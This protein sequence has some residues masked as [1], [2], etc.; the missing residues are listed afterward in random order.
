M[1]EPR[2]PD[3]AS[4]PPR[5][6]RALDPAAFAAGVRASL[7]VLAGVV[8]FG[9]VCG[10]ALAASGIAPAAAVAM[11]LLVFAGA[12]MIAA[13]QLLA[14]GTPAALVVLAAFCI[15]LRF[16]MYSATLRPHFGGMPLRWRLGLAYLLADNPYALAL[17][18]FAERPAALPERLGF[19]LGASLPVWGAWQ[20]AVAAGAYGGARLPAHW[21][22][23]FAAP[24]AFIAIT[25]PFLRGRPAVAAA[26]ASAV[27]SVAL[28]AL[29]WRLGVVVAA[30]A[31]IGAALLAERTGRR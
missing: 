12:S 30:A 8:P 16:A 11:S 27:T 2:G 4:V 29:P 31:G 17:A 20:I 18:R 6:K 28:A 15:N 24:L 5:R 23:E 7:A 1:H 19:Y 13:A 9:L 25:V 21:K 22:L 14:A 10:V 26:L 3:P